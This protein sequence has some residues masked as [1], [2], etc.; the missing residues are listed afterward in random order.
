MRVCPLAHPSSAQ[1]ELEEGGRRSPREPRYL[2]RPTS[3]RT[4]G[5]LPPSAVANVQACA[6][7]KFR[8]SRLENWNVNLVD[9]PEDVAAKLAAFDFDGESLNTS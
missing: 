2:E 9:L 3:P 1:M 8:A 7:K 5:V 4:G 6:S